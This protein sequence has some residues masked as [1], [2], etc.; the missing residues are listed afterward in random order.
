MSSGQRL[1]L[2]EVWGKAVELRDLLSPSCDQIE[3]AGSLRRAAG[4]V[5]TLI[6]DIELV[7]IPK[8]TPLVFGV[9][10]DRQRNSLESLLLEM[11][12]RDVIRRDPPDLAVYAWGPKYKKLWIPVSGVWFQVDLFLADEKN[13]SAIYTIRTGPQEFS[14]AL[15]THIRYKTPY[16]QE[17]GYLRLKANGEIVPVRT[18]R[19]YFRLAG[20]KW[21]DPALRVDAN[22]VQPAKSR[23]A[24]DTS[25][26]SGD[27]KQLGMF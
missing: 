25:A 17:E 21:I 16:M 6:G 19:D 20:V 24:D 27:A 7:A 12:G 23:P 22:S 2:G 14:R 11:I 15:V 10:A 4:V 13:Y 18:E 26:P 9:P 1:K 8:K 3:I 5:D